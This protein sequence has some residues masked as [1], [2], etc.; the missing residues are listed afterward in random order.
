MCGL[1]G[2]CFK[3]GHFNSSWSDT[4][5]IPYP[6]RIK[7]TDH[8]TRAE[9]DFLEQ[10][11]GEAAICGNCPGANGTPRVLPKRD[12]NNGDIASNQNPCRLTREIRYGHVYNLCTLR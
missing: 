8:N 5:N 11:L 6:A 3:T 9:N 10:Q 1:L 4:A 2:P 12:N 7:A